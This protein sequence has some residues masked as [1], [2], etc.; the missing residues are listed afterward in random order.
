VAAPSSPERSVSDQVIARVV[1]GCA[2]FGM[3]L[4]PQPV[5]VA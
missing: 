4:A 2:A 5:G 3:I 1:D